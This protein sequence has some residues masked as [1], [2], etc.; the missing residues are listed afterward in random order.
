MD[1]LF[2]GK[3]ISLSELWILQNEGQTQTH[4]VGV[5]LVQTSTTPNSSQVNYEWFGLII[6]VGYFYLYLFL[7][8]VNF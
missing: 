5:F 3:T 2:W 4:G 1:L 7:I 8:F 6:F